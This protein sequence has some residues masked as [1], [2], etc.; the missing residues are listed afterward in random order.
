MGDYDKAIECYEKSLEK[1]NKLGERLGTIYCYS[2][3]GRT[4]EAMGKHEKALVHHNKALAMRE[5]M[6][7]KVGIAR[8]HYYISFVF[9]NKQQNDEALKSLIFAK[10]IFEEFETQTGFRHPM[11]GEVQERFRSLRL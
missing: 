9:F 10:S 11:L 1:Y 7:Y 2:G 4:Y 6:E 5:E 3:L 8:E